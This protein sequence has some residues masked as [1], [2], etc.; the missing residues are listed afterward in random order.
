MANYRTIL[1]AHGTSAELS[2]NSFKSKSQ[3]DSYPAKNLKRPRRAELNYF[4][5]LPN[6]ERPESL[7]LERVSLLS[8]LHIRNNRQTV[9]ERMAKTFGYRRQEIVHE[10]ARI[11]NVVE[12]WPALFQMEEVSFGAKICLFLFIWY[13]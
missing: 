1:K 5:P 3:E 9:K 11:A 10:Q 7:E 2:L 4:P 13:S 8:E 6:G 12:R